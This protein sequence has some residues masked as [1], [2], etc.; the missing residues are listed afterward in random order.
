[1]PANKEYHHK[2]YEKNK[3]R[4]LDKQK[5]R[6]FKKRDEINSYLHDY[7]ETH[8][9]V[10]AN[11]QRQYRVKNCKRTAIYMGVIDSCPKCGAKGYRVYNLTTNSQTDAENLYAIVWH[12]AYNQKGVWAYYHMCYVGKGKL[13]DTK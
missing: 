11:K 8:F 5:K 10:Q 12:Y 1:L 7:R 13:W 6:R 2:Y 9:D 4:L 3:A